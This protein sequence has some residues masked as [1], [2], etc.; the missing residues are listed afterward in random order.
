LYATLNASDVAAGSPLFYLKG[1]ASDINGEAQL[2]TLAS[3][4]FTDFNH[5]VING[6]VLSMP[7]LANEVT[8]VSNLDKN[9]EIYPN[10]ANHSVTLTNAAGSSLKIYNAFGSLVAETNIDKDAQTID[11]SALAGGTYFMR[12]N[13]NDEISIRKLTIVK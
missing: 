2:S 9:I 6:V 11:V 5:N 12:I 13:N 10:P 4:K 1:T 3:G 8:S 7:V